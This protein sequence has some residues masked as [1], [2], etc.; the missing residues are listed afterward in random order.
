MTYSALSCL[1]HYTTSLHLFIKLIELGNRTELSFDIR[2]ICKILII[3]HLSLFKNPYSRQYLF[4]LF[5]LLGRS[6]LWYVLFFHLL[7]N[8]FSHRITVLLFI[9]STMDTWTCNCL[10]ISNPLDDDYFF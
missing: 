6:F 1:I 10:N 5:S 4:L 7:S 8:I 9:F 3:L 2:N